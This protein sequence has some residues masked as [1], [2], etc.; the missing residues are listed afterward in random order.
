MRQIA[1]L[2]DG[3]FVKTE[4]AMDM[5]QTLLRP[6]DRAFLEGDTVERSPALRVTA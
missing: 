6:G 4:N 1:P 3:L 5:L 2:M